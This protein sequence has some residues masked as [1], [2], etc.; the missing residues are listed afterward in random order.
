[1]E[2]VDADPPHRLDL[3]LAFV[4][5]FKSQNTTR[6]SLADNGPG[7]TSVTWAMDSPMPLMM[8]IMNAFMHMDDKIGTDFEKG[9][10]KLSSLATE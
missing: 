7:S 4:K 5:P 8:R 10:T 2:I 1:M 3:T 6:F 9:L